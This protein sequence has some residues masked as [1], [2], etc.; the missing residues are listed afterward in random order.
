MTRRQSKNYL[1]GGIVAYSALPR[2]KEFRGQKSA[3][4]F[5]ASIFGINQYIFLIDYLPNGQTINA[6]YY[7]SLLVQLNDIL[8]RKPLAA[9]MSPR[10]LVLA[11]QRPGSAGNC[12]Q[13]RTGLPL[14]P[15]S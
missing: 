12:N 5:L 7:L 15:V 10:D 9:G 14:F 13:V 11:R 1:S 8:K 4:K 2:P 6:E 3:G